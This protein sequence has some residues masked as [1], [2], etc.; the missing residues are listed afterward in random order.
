VDAP[1]FRFQGAAHACGSRERVVN[2]SDANSTPLQGAEDERKK[3]GFVSDVPHDAKRARLLASPSETVS[4]RYYGQSCA[5]VSTGRSF[6]GIWKPY[7]EFSASA[8]PFA[9][10]CWPSNV[11]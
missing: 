1:A 9:I 8:A 10:A 7:V 6:F 2:R 3:P 4:A 11:G 5:A